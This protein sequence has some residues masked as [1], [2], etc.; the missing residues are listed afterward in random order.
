MGPRV[1]KRGHSFNPTL[2]RLAL[3]KREGITQVYHWFQSH[4][5]SIS[6]WRVGGGDNRHPLFQSHP[7]SISTEPEAPKNRR[8]P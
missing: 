1:D 7:G 4:P 5:G 3:F 8:A 6:T 2:V